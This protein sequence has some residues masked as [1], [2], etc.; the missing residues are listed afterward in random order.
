[1]K[2]EYGCN[3]DALFQLKNGKWCC[4]KSSNSCEVNRK[5]N[6]EKRR[7]NDTSKPWAEQ[8]HKYYNCK[9]CKDIIVDSSIKQH[10]AGCYLNPKNIKLCPVCNKPIKNWRKS[11][12]C[13]SK[14]AN[15]KGNNKYT[16]EEACNKGVAD[17]V[18]RRICFE[19]HEKKCVC[20]NERNVV[21]VH[22]YDG[23]RLNNDPINLIP[24]CPTHHCYWH[25]KYKN[26]IEKRVEMYRNKFNVGR[27]LK[28]KVSHCE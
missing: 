21:A 4:S 5:R 2:C 9:W 17:D 7:L 16:I 26:L 22:H 25:G 13:S 1:M 19:H 8:H 24:L 12:R 15:S 11:K 28:D 10:E 18:Y 6:S 3:K 27:G 20:C 23:N 14:C